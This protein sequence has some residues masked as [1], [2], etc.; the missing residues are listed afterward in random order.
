MKC[1]ACGAEAA[2]SDAICLECGQHLIRYPTGPVPKVAHEEL[3]H[4]EVVPEPEEPRGPPRLEAVPPL[5]ELTPEPPSVSKMTGPQAPFQTSGSVPAP[6]GPRPRHRDD[7]EHEIRCPG[8]GHV[9][10]GDATRCRVCGAPY[11]SHS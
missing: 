3:A 7:D 2:P 6:A 4:E 8:C 9:F 5:E 10:V 11:R 1:S